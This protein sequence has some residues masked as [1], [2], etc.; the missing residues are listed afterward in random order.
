MHAIANAW[1]IAVIAKN[2][3]GEAPTSPDDIA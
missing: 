2:A 3:A 1:K